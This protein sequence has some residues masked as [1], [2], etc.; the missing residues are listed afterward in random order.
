MLAVASRPSQWAPLPHELLFV[1]AEDRKVREH[2]TCMNGVE[3]ETVSEFATPIR[4]R[5]PMCRRCNPTISSP[6]RPALSP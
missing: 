6:N 1:F 4:D 3:A 2:T 5:R